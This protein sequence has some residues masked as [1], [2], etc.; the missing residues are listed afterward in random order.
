MDKKDIKITIYGAGLVIVMFIWLII[1]AAELSALVLVKTALLIILSYIAMLF[2]INIKR[3]P[4]SLVVI[5]AAGWLLVIASAISSDANIG[6]KLL[7][8]STYGL[9]IGGGLFLL[10]YIVSKKGL[11]G[12]DVKF[13][14][15]T[16]LYLGFA[17]TTYAILFGTILAALT[18]LI[19]IALKK[20]GRKDTIPLVPFL[21]IG[22]M[23]TVFTS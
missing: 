17:K 14:A 8:D 11:G 1:C 3:V 18:G 13:M 7:A 23:I 12:G 16:G 21:F 20:K 10:V 2:D 6:I 5:M 19:L 15:V 22:I 4:N 9:L